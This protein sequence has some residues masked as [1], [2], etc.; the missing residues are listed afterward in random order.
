MLLMLPSYFHYYFKVTEL[1]SCIESK[2]LSAYVR[3]SWVVTFSLFIIHFHWLRWF[4]LCAGRDGGALHP[5]RWAA[6]ATERRRERMREGYWCAGRRFRR[7]CA[8]L[9]SA[10]LSWVELSWAEP[11]VLS[12][13]CIVFA[14]CLTVLRLSCTRMHLTLLQV[15]YLGRR[16]LQSKSGTMTTR[17]SARC[18]P[19]WQRRYR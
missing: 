4:I 5:A 2:F 8:V 1:Q 10:V 6:G 3:S 16:T 11:F 15:T 14:M 12:C 13:V 9:T 19:I 17:W 7:R 18:Q